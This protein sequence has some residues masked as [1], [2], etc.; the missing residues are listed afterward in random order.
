MIP[1]ELDSHV[2]SGSEEI[3]SPSIRAVPLI[4]ILVPLDF[5]AAS[6][7]AID[8][9]ASIARRFS[10][11]AYLAHIVTHDSLAGAKL[12]L[13]ARDRMD[14]I[15]KT[16]RLF[17]VHNSA[18]V[19]EGALWPTIDALVRQY[20]IDLVVVGVDPKTV[21]EK[22]VVGSNAEEILRKSQIP[23]FTV[24]PATTREP[25]FEAEFKSILFATD[26]GR[27]AEAQA[28]Y[29]V[30]L[31]QEHRAKLTLLHALVP[32]RHPSGQ[33]RSAEEAASIQQM[34]TLVPSGPT[35]GC[36]L[37]FKVLVGDP[38]A[39]ILLAADELKADLIVMGAKAGG[40]VASHLPHTK[41]YEVVCNAPCA[42][43]TLRS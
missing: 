27:T 35:P 30:A 10:A 18:M 14:A 39:N 6:D 36:K 38:V 7:R 32:P 3:G 16:G 19:V 5:S 13:D 12:S 43:L 37:E 2:Q 4:N 20:A 33:E 17:G 21:A 15:L 31:A 1:A 41:A 25:Q 9:A 11:T 22:L 24:G 42:V 34:K 40:V 29:A 23:V 8:Y 28:E 26:F